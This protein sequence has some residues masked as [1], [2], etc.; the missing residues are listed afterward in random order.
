MSG[1]EIAGLVLG[2]IPLIIS[3]LEHWEELLDPA[4]A[5]WKY[6]GELGL[7]IKE[8]RNQHAS[9]EQSLELILTQATN[10]E[11]RSEMME[12]SNSHYWKDPDIEE[13]LKTKFGRA[14]AAYVATTKDIQ[15]IMILLVEKL[16][17]DGAARLSQ[18]GLE[19][20]ISCH[21]KVGGSLLS[22]FEFRNRIKFTMKRQL[23]TK[24]LSELQRLIGMLDGYHSKAEQIQSQQV[25]GYDSKSN[26]MPSLQNIQRDTANLYHVL[27]KTWCRTHP[28][29]SAGLLLEHRLWKKPKRG[30]NGWQG[31]PKKSLPN[32]C[33]TDRFGIS[34]L[35]SINP[36]KWLDVEIRLVESHYPG[37][38]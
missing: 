3:A 9:Y 7:A 31:Y 5:Y 21:P 37:K 24:S 25:Y 33:E 29:H 17:I 18:A 28:T 26:F 27:A 32:T 6:H 35:E 19:A 12:N 10:D 13:A 34:L 2:S 16:N 30:T 14:Y 23:I 1:V 38:T 22:R 15:T 8:L 11:Q 4:I 20:I 36:Q